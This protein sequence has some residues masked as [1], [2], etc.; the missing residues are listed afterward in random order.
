MRI[1]EVFLGENTWELD[2]VDDDGRVIAEAG[3]FN[4]FEDAYEARRFAQ[5]VA[6]AYVDALLKPFQN[7]S[8]CQKKKRPH[9]ERGHKDKK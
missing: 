2:L 6:L 9:D 4:S 1:E 7:C 5:A 8:G 3:D